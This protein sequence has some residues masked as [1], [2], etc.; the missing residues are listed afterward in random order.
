MSVATRVR[1]QRY[2]RKPVLTPH[3]TPG[4]RQPTALALAAAGLLGRIADLMGKHV[5]T[6]EKWSQGERGPEFDCSELFPALQR[7]GVSSDRAGM[8][9]ARIKA[10]Y[11][12]AYRADLPSLRELQKPETIADH[13]EDETQIDCVLHEGDLEAQARHLPNVLAEIAMLET[14]AARITQN[15]QAAGRM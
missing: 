2:I 1:S 7:A 10:F 5:N 3:W 14:V 11:E 8:I 12:A 13:A 6:L 4:D 15:L 9:V